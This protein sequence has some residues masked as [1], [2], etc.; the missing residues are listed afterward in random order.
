[1]FLNSFSNPGK[2]FF[3]AVEIFTFIYKGLIPLKYIFSENLYDTF[4][5]RYNH[6]S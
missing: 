4:Y 6:H 1:M 2:E 5:R 3:F